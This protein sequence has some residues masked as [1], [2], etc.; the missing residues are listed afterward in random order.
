MTLNKIDSF[1]SRSH[2]IAVESKLSL[3]Q[4]NE[5]KISYS[6]DIKIP[7]HIVPIG[8]GAILLLPNENGDGS[9]YWYFGCT[10]TLENVIDMKCTQ[11]RTDLHISG[12][13][14]TF[15][16]NKKYENI[17]LLFFAQK[18]A[19]MSHENGF[20]DAIEVDNSLT[21][22]SVSKIVYLNE[23]TKATAVYFFDETKSKIDD[24]SFQGDRIMVSVVSR[25]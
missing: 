12:E 19:S 23:F 25:F 22:E 3:I 21:A 4:Q 24:I 13:D 18:N 5:L 2:F 20:A 10:K 11:Y 1:T 7:K 6:S 8:K 9:S 17:N 15:S 16:L 14:Y